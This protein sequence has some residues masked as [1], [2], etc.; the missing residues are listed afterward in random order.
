MPFNPILQLF[1]KKECDI[2]LSISL[3]MNCWRVDMW[4]LSSRISSLHH[5]Q[6]TCMLITPHRRLGEQH[7]W[8]KDGQ[9]SHYI[10]QLTT[11]LSSSKNLLFPGNNHLLTTGAM[12]WHFNY[13][14]SASEGDNYSLWPSAMVVSRWLWP[15]NRI[16]GMWIACWF[17]GA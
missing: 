7:T 16:F 11:M 17:A 5:E 14:P 3:L 8:C 6:H 1:F 10:H 9:K 4:T 12:S 15:G 2:C 13:R